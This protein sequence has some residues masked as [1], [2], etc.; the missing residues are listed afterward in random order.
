LM[1]RS[2]REV[3]ANIKSVI[4]HDSALRPY[5]EAE[6]ASVENVAS[7]LRYK[8]WLATQR[9]SQEFLER[10]TTD[11]TLS[12]TAR[13][14]EAIARAFDEYTYEPRFFEFDDG[15]TILLPLVRARRRPRMLRCFEAMPFSLNGMFT[16]DATCLT[17]DHLRA[18]VD[19]LRP[20]VLQLNTGA[21]SV[22]GR[23]VPHFDGLFEPIDSSSH[24]LELDEGMQAIWTRRFSSKVRNQCRLAVRKGVQ[25]RTA[26]R[27]EEFDTYYSIYEAA[28]IQWGYQTAPYPDTLFRE[29]GTL[30]GQGVELKLAY[31]GE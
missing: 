23:N 2:R 6:K 19:W 7:V 9:E 17:R 13:L 16:S 20:D 5:R 30:V 29:I 18:V 10:S 28:T 25:V 12:Q 24:I 15:L 27:P 26:T 3:S 8:T 31:V 22:T 11:Y 21:T 1:M 4:G 14:G